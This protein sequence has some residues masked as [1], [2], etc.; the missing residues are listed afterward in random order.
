MSESVS[1]RV[2]VN[3]E[4]PHESDVEPRL[5]LVHYL[6]DELGALVIIDQHAVEELAVAATDILTRD[7][8]EW[9]TEG[10]EVGG[11]GGLLSAGERD[12]EAETWAA[13]RTAAR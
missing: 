9:N 11:V 13:R 5:L 8:L 7:E 1:I 12:V 3:G 4:F 6:R 10:G 2:T